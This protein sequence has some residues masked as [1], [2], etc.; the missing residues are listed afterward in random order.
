MRERN[1]RHWVNL[2][3]IQRHSELL[4]TRVK[5]IYVDTLCQPAHIYLFQINSTIMTH[6]VMEM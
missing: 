3:I 2:L 4:G 5:S 1:D 6:R